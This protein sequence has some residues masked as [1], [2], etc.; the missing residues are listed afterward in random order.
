M[1]EIQFEEYE[2]SNTS[3]MRNEARKQSLSERVAYSTKLVRTPAGAR[4]FWLVCIVLM[5]GLS[6]F[7]L[8]GQDNV[9]E[10]QGN[11]SDILERYPDLYSAD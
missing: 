5:I 7:L 10:R 11:N 8:T 9:A 6:V 3:A 1:S 4:I 2:P